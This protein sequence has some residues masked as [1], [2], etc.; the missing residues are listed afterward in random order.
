MAEKKRFKA[1]RDGVD[2]WSEGVSFTAPGGE[3]VEVLYTK[4]KGGEQGFFVELPG[5]PACAHG[6][7]LEE[8]IDAAREKRDGTKPLSEEEKSAYKLENYKFTLA[9]FK[10]IT[11][12]CA[13]GARAWLAERKLPPSVTMTLSEFRAAGGGQWAD[14]LEAKLGK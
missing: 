14:I 13:S 10:R 8:A 1:Y 5:T 11:G 12:A 7:T 4:E 6:D 9:L 2:L 3:V